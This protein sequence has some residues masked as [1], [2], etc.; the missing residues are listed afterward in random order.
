VGFKKIIEELFKN[1]ENISAEIKAEIPLK[2]VWI[3]N[4]EEDI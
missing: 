4:L 3:L 1:Y 2:K